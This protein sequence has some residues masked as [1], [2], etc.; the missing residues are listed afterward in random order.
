MNALEGPKTAVVRNPA[1][2]PRGAFAIGLGAYALWGVLPIYF[3]MLSEVPPVDIVAHR[4]LWSLPFLALLITATRGWDKV[5]A[6]ALRPKTVA[7]LALT[8]LLICR[9]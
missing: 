1:Q 6:A 9:N 7:M 4:V 2:A 8:A 5:R 3:K